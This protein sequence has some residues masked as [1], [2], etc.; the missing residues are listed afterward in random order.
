MCALCRESLRRVHPPKF[1]LLEAL[2]FILSKGTT[3]DNWRSTAGMFTL[4]IQLFEV[5]HVLL[6]CSNMQQYRVYPKD[7]FVPCTVRVYITNTLPTR[8]LR[9]N[10]DACARTQ[11]VLMSGT[12]TTWYGP[13]ATDY[14]LIIHIPRGI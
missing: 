11:L 3:I 9:N 1:A 5:V 14:I 2:T 13:H 6:Y 7:P 12:V 4:Y 10:A 8:F